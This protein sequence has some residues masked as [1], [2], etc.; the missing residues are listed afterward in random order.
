MS[1]NIHSNLTAIENQLVNA[2]KGAFG[3][4]LYTRIETKAKQKLT[5]D[6]HI[7]TGRLRASIMTDIAD[8]HNNIK[9]EVGTNVPYAAKIEFR[10]DS[11]LG[12]AFETEKNNVVIDMQIAARGVIR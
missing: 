6:G 8:N 7:D 9:G 3:R 11:Y 5:A 1:S 10:Y 2:V 12:Y 4:A